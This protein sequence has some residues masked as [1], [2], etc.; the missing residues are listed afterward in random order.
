MGGPESEEIGIAGAGSDEEDQRL[1]CAGGG[2]SVTY[3]GLCL[4][5]PLVVHEDLGMGLVRGV[6][7]GHG[8]GGAG[9]EAADVTLGELMEEELA[10]F[11]EGLGGD[12]LAAEVAEIG[13]PVAEV[14]GELGVDLFAEAL[15][16]GG[17]WHRRWRWRPGGRRG[18]R[19][20][21]SRSRRRVGRRRR[22]RGCWRLRLR[23]RRRG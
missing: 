18:G 17:C 8:A 21:G 10:L 16:E 11:V 2:H 23:R 5:L 20:R 13:E 1:P 3:I 15:G 12:D 19:R 22:C 7:A 6:A 9:V 14:E 4:G